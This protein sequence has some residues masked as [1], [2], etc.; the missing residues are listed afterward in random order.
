[1]SGKRSKRLR[2]EESGDG[3]APQTQLTRAEA[4]ALFKRADAIGEFIAADADFNNAIADWEDA[5][6]S[7]ML[8]EEEA[9]VVL[10]DLSDEV[11]ALTA[12]DAIRDEIAAD[13]NALAAAARAAAVAV[14]ADAVAQGYPPTQAVV[15]AVAYVEAAKRVVEEWPDPLPMDLPHGYAE[16]FACRPYGR[17]YAAK[18]T[19]RFVAGDSPVEANH[20]A[21]EAAKKAD[22]AQ[23]LDEFKALLDAYYD[24][25]ETRPGIFHPSIY[26]RRMGDEEEWA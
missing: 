17:T 3:D 9:S 5:A 26:L 25:L 11:G 18:Y 4:R 24:H 12:I 16:E 6:E 15:Y 7:I 20:A 13:G 22:D 19:E 21:K 2:R 14:R 10:A 8:R 1:M 23:S